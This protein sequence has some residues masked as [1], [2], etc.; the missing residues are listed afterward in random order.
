MNNE[1]LY[2]NKKDHIFVR[3]ITNTY[4]LKNE[5]TRLHTQPHVRKANNIKF[6]N[7]P[8]TFSQHYIKPKDNITQTFHLHLKEYSPDSKSQKH[9]HINEAAFYILDNTDYEIHNNIRYDWNANNITIMHN[10]Y[11]H[12]HFNANAIKPTQTLI[13]KTKPMYLSKMHLDL[14]RNFQI[15]P[16]TK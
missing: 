1:T 6:I 8:Q 4:N 14:K 12:Q 16:D 7:E 3:T 11:I 2:H 13:I 5:L 10:N 9:D 15:M